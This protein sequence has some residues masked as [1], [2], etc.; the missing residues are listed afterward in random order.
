MAGGSGQHDSAN[1]NTPIMSDDVPN[2]YSE[3]LTENYEVTHDMDDE[4]VSD[5]LESLSGSD[6]EGD[7]NSHTFNTA[8]QQLAD[9]AKTR[10]LCKGEIL[11]KVEAPNCPTLNDI[12]NEGGG[13]DDEADSTQTSGTDRAD[14]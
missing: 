3:F 5:D 4:Y 11:V 14:T 10:L 7:V 8:L 2:V 1:V 13:T 9:L 12:P 6:G